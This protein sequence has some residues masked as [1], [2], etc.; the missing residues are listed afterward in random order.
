MENNQDS[1]IN[2]L[3]VIKKYLT[4]IFDISSDT[5]KEATI[6]DIKSGIYVKGQTAWVLIFSILIASAGLNT[7]STAVVIGAMLI[8][9]LMGPILGMGLSLGIN[10]ID[11]LRKA[12]EEFCRY[13]DS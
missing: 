5:D 9:P 4:E 10:D 3:A 8:S 7:S 2:I 6:E 11:F 12:L 13:G 1:N